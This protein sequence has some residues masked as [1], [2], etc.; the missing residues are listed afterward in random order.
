MYSSGF[1]SPVRSIEKQTS[2]KPILWRL[3][4]SDA[5]GRNF[6]SSNPI[7]FGRPTI[8]TLGSSATY[9]AGSWVTI[10]GVVG[11]TDLNGTFRVLW[12]SGS[13]LAIDY[14][15]GESAAWVSG[16]AVASAIIKD[17][18]NVFS[19]MPIQGVTT[20]IFDNPS[21]GLTPAS[22]GSNS[23]R[24]TSGLTEFDLTTHTGVLVIG[25]EGYKAASP[26][27]IEYLFSLGR[28]A[29]TGAN[30]ASG[31]ISARINTDGQIVFFVRPAS[32]TDGGASNTSLFSG[33]I[34]N[35]T[36]FKIALVLDMTDP[37][38]WF[39]HLFLNGVLTRSNAV[40][41][42]G[43]SGGI[44]TANGVAFG[45]DMNA[46]L[47]LTNLLGVGGSGCRVRNMLWWKTNKS[48]TS[49]IRAVTKFHLSDSLE[50][51]I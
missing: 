28:N 38:N 13:S 4:Q 7:Q 2:G 39:A 51:F 29:A 33:T 19:A 21:F 17:E 3:H 47:A 49:V 11:P 36:R 26:T 15:S 14:D 6:A 1:I 8:I 37:A 20:N 24:Q 12:C 32:A 41:M 40:T 34:A 16:G 27:S 23:P 35:T 42:T 25:F 9:M 43:A 44:S 31:N 10:S 5:T 18:F 45:A 50:G 22:G 48:V 46:S 30:S